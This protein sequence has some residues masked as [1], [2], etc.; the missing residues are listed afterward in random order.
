MRKH[1]LLSVFVVA[2]CGN[3]FAAD[4]TVITRT[5]AAVSAGALTS[6]QSLDRIT[7]EANTLNRPIALANDALLAAPVKYPVESLK[8]GREGRVVLDFFVDASG[9]V[10]ESVVRHSSGS[11]RLDAAAMEAARKWRFTPELKNG[12]TVAARALMPVD[13]RIALAD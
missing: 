4:S 1:L 8:R 6:D 11:D 7:V 10:R 13:F 3:V 9:A 5:L 12:S 2:A